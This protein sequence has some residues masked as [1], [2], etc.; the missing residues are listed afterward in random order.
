MAPSA[1]MLSKIQLLHAQLFQISL[2]FCAFSHFGALHRKVYYDADVICHIN[3]FTQ[4]NSP[5]VTVKK[6]R[7]IKRFKKF[8][9]T[10]DDGF[11]FSD[12][13]FFQSCYIDTEIFPGNP[14]QLLLDLGK[15]SVQIQRPDFDP[16][17]AH[18]VFILRIDLL[19]SS[20]IQQHA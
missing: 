19:I 3:G 14:I 13:S 10:E 8:A 5:S 16:V 15:V 11:I 20:G 1:K 6:H 9:S 7:N 12:H 2:D 4:S 18:V 17:S